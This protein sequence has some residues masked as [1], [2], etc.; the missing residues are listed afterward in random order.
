MTDNVF[1]LKQINM[2]SATI[3]IPLSKLATNRMQNKGFDKKNKTRGKKHTNFN[4]IIRTCQKVS[5]NQVCKAI[6]AAI[7]YENIMLLGTSIEGY[8]NK[9]CISIDSLLAV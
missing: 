3:G 5:R 1:T 4:V 7:H 6:T 9:K 2:N 8:I